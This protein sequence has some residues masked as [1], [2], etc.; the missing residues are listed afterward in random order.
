MNFLTCNFIP[1][2]TLPTRVRNHSI[3]LIDHI[4]IKTPRKLL[5]NKCLSCD[6]ITD[7]S[8][9]LANFSFFD[10]KTPSINDRPYI[11]LFTEKRIKSFKENL[12]S[13]VSLVENC[14]FLEVNTTYDMFSSNYIK[15][16]N[17]GTSPARGQAFPSFIA[18]CRR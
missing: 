1:Y 6:L 11:R 10:I 9:H 16:Y 2:I 5:Q 7:I 3:S 8:D 13:E 17:D 14:D 18:T 15:L 4:F 12:N